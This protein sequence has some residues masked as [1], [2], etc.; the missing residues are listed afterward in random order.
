MVSRVKSKISRIIARLRGAS[1]SV[2]PGT[3]TCQVRGLAIL[4]DVESEIEVF[5]AET[6]ASKEPETL[7]WIERFFRSEDVIYDIGANVGLYSLFAAKHLN[8]RCKVY[9]FEP[10][11]LNYA[12]LNI[13][14]YIN[15]LS[16]TIVPCCLGACRATGE[17]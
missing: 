1:G 15:G 2:R 12:K 10:E 16:G 6:Y 8:S 11:A 5:R 4:L 17:V 3:V 7:E 14:I 9:A 13:N